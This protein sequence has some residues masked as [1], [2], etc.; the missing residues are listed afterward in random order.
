M[1]QAGILLGGAGTRLGL[2]DR[3]KPMLDFCGK[4]LLERTVV[5]LVE[6]GVTDLIFLTHHMGEVIQEWFGDGSSYGAKI[7]YCRET[8]PRGTAGAALN[9]RDLWQ[10]EF[11]MLY[12][13][14]I[15]DVDL[16]LFIKTARKK[17]GAGTLFVHPNDH[18]YDSDLVQ[19]DSNGRI[20]SIH[21]KPHSSK[22][23]LRNR[24]N[25]GLYYFK[26]EIFD[27]VPDTPGI[28]DWGR[29]IF[30]TAVK[31]GVE[32]YAY[33]SAEY[34]KDIG[35]KERVAKAE[36]HWRTGI[37]K[38]RSYRVKQRAIFLIVTEL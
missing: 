9:A 30:P 6:Q 2:T 31:N 36:E 20:K 33:N 8:V 21:G 1:I 5:T 26:K 3:P 12:G 18:P 10:D 35:T 17:G 28:L 38:S 29:D 27:S 23:L 22:I 25:A 37:I 32:L 11:L 16:A 4:P 13:D 24:V 7:Q 15:F 34:I 19:Y 14:T